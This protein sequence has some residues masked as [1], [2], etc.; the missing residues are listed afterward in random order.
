MSM[1][2]MIRHGQASFGNDNYDKLSE[3]G[4]VQSTILGEHLVNTGILFDAVYSGPLSRQEATAS[5]VFNIFKKKGLAFPD[6][7]VMQEFK[8]Y[9]PTAVLMSQIPLV[10]EEDP[11]LKQYADL[12]YKDNKAFQRLFEK[13][14]L[15]WVSGMNDSPGVE[16]WE[17]LTTRVKHGIEHIMK[18]HGRSKNIAVFTSGGPISAVMQMCLGLTN[19]HAIRLNWQVINTSISRFMYNQER[20][21]LAGFNNISHL[22]L[23]HGNKL[24]TYR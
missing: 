1:I 5:L 4:I 14:L 15:K 18:T 19:E 2:Y 22:E 9:D 13:S 21:T 7:S 24:I 3:N 23:A 10:L 6:L 16:T 12:I 17:S 11:S 8:E 20:L